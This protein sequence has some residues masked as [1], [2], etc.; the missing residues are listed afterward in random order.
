MGKFTPNEGP[1][2]RVRGGPQ[3]KKTFGE[4]NT[5]QPGG[6]NTTEDIHWT[7]VGGQWAASPF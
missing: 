6:R 7:G 3:W 2:E 5:G 1:L 4:L